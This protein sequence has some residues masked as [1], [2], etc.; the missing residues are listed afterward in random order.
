MYIISCLDTKSNKV[1]RKKIESPY[2]LEK[3]VQIFR[4]SKTINL[5][6]WVSIF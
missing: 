4:R 2:L 6:G 5:L 1:F 3:Y